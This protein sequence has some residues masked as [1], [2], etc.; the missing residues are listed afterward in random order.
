MR[1]H[2]KG[3][4]N[5]TTIS[6]SQGMGSFK[7]GFRIEEKI[8]KYRLVS[9]F[10]DEIPGQETKNLHEFIINDLSIRVSPFVRA[11]ASTY[12][13]KHECRYIALCT[14]KYSNRTE[15]NIILF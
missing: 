7:R 10:T 13:Y 1:E 6:G 4:Q 11:Y 12:R 5:P 14:I 3:G 8:R 15:P 2:T 9:F